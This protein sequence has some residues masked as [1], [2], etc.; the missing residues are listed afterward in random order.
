MQH[1]IVEAKNPKWVDSNHNRIDL[2]V[3]F[4]ELEEDFLFFTASPD[5]VCE[6]SRTLYN[7]AVAG[8]YGQ[9]ADEY[10]VTEDDLWTPVTQTITTVS[11]ESLVQ[12]LLEKGV[13][14]DEDVDEILVDEEVSVGYTKPTKDGSNPV[15][16]SPMTG[17]GV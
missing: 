2:E 6:H 1:T 10:T 14:T 15:Y 8:D 16:H 5:D 9:V 11:K 13:L 7:K 3:N 4:A 12:I 17:A